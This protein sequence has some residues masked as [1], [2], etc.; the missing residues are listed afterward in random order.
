MSGVGDVETE[1][2]TGWYIRSATG[3]MDAEQIDQTEDVPVLGDKVPPFYLRVSNTSGTFQRFYT[4][5][6]DYRP[7]IDHSLVLSFEM[8]AGLAGRVF[9]QVYLELENSGGSPTSIF[10]Q[11]LS[12]TSSY[13]DADTDWQT[14]R[15]PVPSIFPGA[16]T[17]FGPSPQIRVEFQINGPSADRAVTVDIRRVKLARGFD[18]GDFIRNA[19]D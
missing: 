19:N 5:V 18:A 8:K 16:T 12:G 4:R 10:N 3:T 6:S 9:N 13:L 14:Y 2:A 7:L 11:V 17:T 1:V 15:L